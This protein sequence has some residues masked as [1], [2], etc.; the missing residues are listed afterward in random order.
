MSENLGAHINT[1]GINVRGALPFVVFLAADLVFLFCKIKGIVLPIIVIPRSFGIGKDLLDVFVVIFIPWNGWVF[2]IP[3]LSA[4]MV[5]TK[6]NRLL[7]LWAL[8]SITTG[9]IS[10]F[11][12][13]R[14]LS[15]HTLAVGVLT[16]G[17]INLF[18]LI[19]MSLIKLTLGRIDKCLQ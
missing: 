6:A 16:Y 2:A 7:V 18:V 9:I 8:S 13:F 11:F 17:A 3:L 4:Y 19:L 14:D 5:D 1:D 15:L 10:T 12:E